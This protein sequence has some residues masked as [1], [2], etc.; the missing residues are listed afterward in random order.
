M[1][2][3]YLF[4]LYNEGLSPILEKKVSLTSLFGFSINKL[5]PHLTLFFFVAN[6]PFFFRAKQGD[7]RTIKEILWLYESNGTNN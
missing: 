1:L 5:Y 2:S 3:L 7:S 4:L 6:S